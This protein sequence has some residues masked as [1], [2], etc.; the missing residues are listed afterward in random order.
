MEFAS[1]AAFRSSVRY[2]LDAATDGIPPARPD[3]VLDM[4]IALGEARV[5]RTLRASTM[6]SDL[7]VAVA[8]NAA[9]LPADLLEL[10]EVYFS[11]E[12]PIEVVPLD[13]LRTYTSIGGG[14]TP[15]YAAQDADA[16]VFYPEASGTLLGSY[17]ARPDAMRSVTWA[18]ATTFARYP[19]VYLHAAVAEAKALVGLDPTISEA[20]FRETLESAMQDERART[21]SAGRLRVRAR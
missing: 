12:A 17:Y 21:Y 1:Y 19:E 10:R 16:L 7:S 2:A 5:H 6:V 15:R 20:K 11:G 3:E 4:A 9:T 18:D 13:R 8:A 14:G